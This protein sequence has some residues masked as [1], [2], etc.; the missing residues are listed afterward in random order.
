MSAAVMVFVLIWGTP[1]GTRLHYSG[2]Y[3]TQQECFLAGLVIPKPYKVFRC[4]RAWQ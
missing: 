3:K 4:K 1:D 2:P